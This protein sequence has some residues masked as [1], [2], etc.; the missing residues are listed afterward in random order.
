MY[1]LT[2]N[3][4]PLV[5]HLHEILFWPLQVIPEQ[6]E[7]TVNGN[8]WEFLKNITEQNPWEEM[9]SAFSSDPHTFKEQYYKEFV[10]F[11]PY[12]QRFLYGENRG[13][14]GYGNSPIRVFRHREVTQV[15]L[16]PNSE[17]PALTL[18]VQQANLLFFYDIDIIIL[19]V[20]VVGHD[21]PLPVAQEVLF[22]FGRTYPA[23]WDS[24]GQAGQCF[25]RVE[26][27]GRNGQVLAESDYE[28][29]E[30]YLDSV[31]KYRAPAIARHWEYLLRPLTLHQATTPAVLRYRQIEYHRMP[32]MAYLTVDDPRELTRADF[33]RLALV[34]RPGDSNQLPYSEASLIDFEQQY[35]YDRFWDPHAA[36]GML[37]SRYLCCG[38][39]FLL[40]GKAGDPF[41]IDP[42]IGLLGQFRRQYFLMCLI[43]H[44]HKA[45]LHLFSEQLITA[46]SHLDI[47]QV[48]SLKQFKRDIRKILST[49]LRFT[50][51]Y[52]FHEVSN[53]A[54][55]RDLFKML[56]DQLGTEQ[57]YRD[58]S[59]A[60]REMN[61]YL[62]GDDLRRQA[63]TVVRLTVVMTLSIIGTVTTGFLG[64]NLFSA[65]DN[66]LFARIIFFL[67]VMIPT[68]LLTLYTVARSKTLSEFLDVLSN[69]HLHWQAK[70]ASLS[71]VWES[72]SK[73]SDHG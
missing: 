39:A 31:G 55:A 48:E 61:Q 69:E 15:R 12:V 17:T 65:A 51:R 18:A 7:H 60:V 11:L 41:F 40:V 24:S 33:V 4:S 59:E 5:R 53:Q 29:R 54:Q 23:F 64:M 27:L 72:R 73:Y 44:F 35:C 37:N 42:E 50:H 70:A 67:L 13:I 28:D 56:T 3:S 43:P 57:I 10:T 52:W 62:E 36:H 21:L 71:K 9:P 30:K 38:H 34:T 66:P 68:G 49:F 16:T 47:Y 8:H 2:H 1:P 58:I 6:P 14:T 45:A 32:L 22:K 19:V 26:W 46:I 25:Q 63:E 20:E